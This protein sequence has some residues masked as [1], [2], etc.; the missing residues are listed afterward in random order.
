MNS[1][2]IVRVS[3]F[4]HVKKVII[5]GAGKASIFFAE[6][7]V[8]QHFRASAQRLFRNQDKRFRD[9]IFRARG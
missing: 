8:F 1:A 9:M 7:N 3:V 5:G 2:W 6:T 4:A